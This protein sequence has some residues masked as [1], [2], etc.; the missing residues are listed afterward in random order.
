M[1][2]ALNQ[3]MIDGLSAE[4]EEVDS[5]VLIGTRGLTVEEVSE[6]RNKLRDQSYR[7]RVVKNTLAKISFEKTTMKGI[8]DYLDGPSAICFGGE[9]GAGAGPLAKLLVQE[10]TAKKDK[11]VI[12]GGFS[13]GEPLDAAGVDALSKAPTRDELLSMT[14]GAFFGPVSEMAK[15]FDGLLTEMHG[16]VEA[17]VEEKGGAG[18]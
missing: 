4:L 14:M 2:K 6:L 10:S 5:C 16:L 11:V 12:Q 18:E 17:L 1:S 9:E 15:N 3:A 8:G 13:E 7:M